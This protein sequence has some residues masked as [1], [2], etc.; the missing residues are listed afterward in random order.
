[1]TPTE[2]AIR[3]DG[4][5]AVG[6]VCCWI[7]RAIGDFECPNL[8]CEVHHLNGGG[9]AGQARRGDEFTV[10]LCFWH[11]RG[12]FNAAAAPG[13]YAGERWMAEKA[14]KF[15]PSWAQ[16]SKVFH[17]Q[18]PSDDELLAIADRLL[19]QHLARAA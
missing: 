19:E 2:R 17:L 18:Y 12:S 14:A 11:H 13:G 8:P 1:M 7:N 5:I 9:H 3:F 16:G 6:C 10:G 15:G 4:L